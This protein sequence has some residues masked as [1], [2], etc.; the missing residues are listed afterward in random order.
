VRARTP[1]T[2]CDD[3]GLADPG[4]G[5]AIDRAGSLLVRQ[6]G[7]PLTRVRLHGA[8]VEH[9][10]V[11]R[12]PSS[13]TSA[14]WIVGG[15]AVGGR[16]RSPLRCPDRSTSRRTT[17]RVVTVSRLVGGVLRRPPSGWGL[18]A[19]YAAW[20]GETL[21]TVVHQFSPFIDLLR[22]K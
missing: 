22:T 15:I 14:Y 1:A 20:P 7:A 5:V 21:L 10:R 2:S 16:L 6:A 4:R 17:P 8:A 9:A 11:R 13:A 19:T 3:V 12:I 18:L